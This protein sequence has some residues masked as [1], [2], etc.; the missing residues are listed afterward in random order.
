MQAIES[1]PSNASAALGLAERTRLHVFDA[2]YLELAL[3]RQGAVLVTN[4]AELLQAGIKELGPQRAFSSDAAFQKFV[5][6]FA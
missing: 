1:P 3:A 2:S 4:D 5:E 6:A